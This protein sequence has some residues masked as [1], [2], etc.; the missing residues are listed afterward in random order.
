MSLP[1][2]VGVCVCTCNRYCHESHLL[3][4]SP[5][6]PFTQLLRGEKGL[7][8]WCLLI[9]RVFPFPTDLIKGDFTLHVLHM[10]Q[11]I[12]YLALVVLQQA[13]TLN[14]PQTHLV[15]IACVSILPFFIRT[16]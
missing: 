12:E 15:Y 14:P 6:R 2:A 3:L 5:A 9:H 16:T 10:E 4:I 1:Q 13:D 7:G 8:A 11:M